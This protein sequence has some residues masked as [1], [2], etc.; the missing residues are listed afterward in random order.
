MARNT[1]YDVIL[2]DIRM[3][4]MDGYEATRLIRG[5]DIPQAKTVPIVAMTA[6]VFR[7]ELNAAWPAA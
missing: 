3:P 5:L 1:T 7:E 4:V 6:N 2:M